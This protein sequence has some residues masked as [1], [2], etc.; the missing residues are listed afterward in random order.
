MPLE[1]HYKRVNTP[2]RKL[3]ARESNVLIAGIAVTPIAILALIFV[4]ATTSGR[5][6][7]N[8]GHRPAASKSPSPAGSAATGRRL[9]RESEG[10]LQAASGFDDPRARNDHRRLRRGRRPVLG[11]V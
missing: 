10:D 5:C 6:S 4:P 2:L 9:R 11:L 7:T 8:G 1:G 3:T